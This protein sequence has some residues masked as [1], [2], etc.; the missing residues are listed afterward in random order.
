[1]LVG[2]GVG[3]GVGEGVKVGLGA[4]V[5]QVLWYVVHGAAL[6][7]LA[8]GIGPGDEVIVLSATWWSSVMPVLHHGA[9]PVFAETAISATR[10]FL[11][12]PYRVAQASSSLRVAATSNCR[13]AAMPRPSLTYSALWQQGRRPLGPS[14]RTWPRP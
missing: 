5:R 14:I 12:V 7:Y 13:K 6:A 1:M 3:V 10:V 8:L 9:V 11:P 2:S 4:G